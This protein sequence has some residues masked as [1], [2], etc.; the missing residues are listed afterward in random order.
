MRFADARLRASIM[1][2]CSMICL[3]IGVECDWI[4]NASQPRTDSSKRTKI[5]PLAKSYADVGVSG[6]PSSVATCSDNSGNPRPEKRRSFFSE[7]KRISL[8]EVSPSARRCCGALQPQQIYCRLAYAEPNLLHFAALP[9]R[10]Q[11]HR[12]EHLL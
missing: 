6:M 9:Y 1:I 3:L 12:A 7:D 8:K 4:T 5:S 11:L 2:S 10:H